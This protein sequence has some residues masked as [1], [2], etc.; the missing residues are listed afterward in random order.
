MSG[1]VER[2]VLV[3][4]RLHLGRIHGYLDAELTPLF[5]ELESGRLRAGLDVLEPDCLPPGHPARKWPNLILT[6]HDA[7]RGW[8]DDHAQPARMEKM[9]LNCLDNLRRFTE[10]RPLRF[11]M[12]RDR[13]LRST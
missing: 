13:Y 3:D 8:P 10:A 6:A 9:H 7:H 5:A 2:S 4:R 11:V 1:H 12:D